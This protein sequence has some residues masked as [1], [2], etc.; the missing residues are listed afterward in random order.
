[1]SSL[2]KPRRWIERLPVKCRD[3][4]EMNECIK[5]HGFTAFI[6]ELANQHRDMVNGCFFLKRLKK[7]GIN[8]AVDASA[9]HTMRGE[10]FRL[11]AHGDARHRAWLSDALKEYFQ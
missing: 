1:M 9:R 11:I 2:P 7:I 5:L 6:Q 4:D 3:A 10:I 8:D